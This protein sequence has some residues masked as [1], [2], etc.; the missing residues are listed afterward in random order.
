VAASFAAAGM[1]TD[2]C[3]GVR[4]GASQNSLWALRGTAGLSSRDG[5]LPLS[6]SQD[7]GGPLARSVS[8]LLLMLDHSVGFDPADETTRA[9]DGNVPRT[10][11]QSVGDAG[12]GDVTIGVLAPLF[13]SSPED[14]EVSRI[15]RDATEDIRSL[16]A[17]LVEAPF[18]G[19][20]D[21]MADTSM[22]EAELESDLQHFLQQYP[23]APVRSLGD[24]LSRGRYEPEL[25]AALGRAHEAASSPS[26]PL[27][28][29]QPYRAAL[30]R[31]EQARQAVLDAMSA[32]GITAFVYPTLRRH[33]GPA[34]RMRI[35]SNCQLSASTGLPAIS[36]PAGVTSGGEPVG[37][38]L[39]GRAWS[40]PKLL[41]IAYA[42]ERLVAPRRPP[43]TVP[44]LT[45]PPPVPPLTVSPSASP[46]PPGGR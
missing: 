35:E 24:L 32:R 12:L 33:P 3:G 20:G 9:S 13:G 36:M 8:D 11:N 17:G 18:P 37:M 46:R 4:N 45:V 38:E 43:S 26:G 41:K 21:V 23:A 6:H 22:I 15:V 2:T 42:Y 1:A 28:G 7:I 5:I 40:E 25:A 14:D 44:P 10:Y 16:G 29:S 30:A 31:R 19:L 34:G 27:A 39:L